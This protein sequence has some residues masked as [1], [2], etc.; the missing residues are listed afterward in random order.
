MKFVLPF[1][2]TFLYTIQSNGQDLYFPPNFSEEWETLDPQDLDWC[3]D[4]ITDFD[5]FLAES[6][7]NAF[8][9][10]KDGKIV[11]EA[12]FNDFDLNSSWYWASAGKTI[13]A[14]MIGI[15]Q[16]EGALDINDATSLYLGEGWTD[17]PSEEGN[18]TIRK[19]Y[20]P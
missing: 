20:Q 8:I 9:A 14:A 3:T 5:N 10:L 11:H 16:E 6:N 12:Y 18:I 2:F 13:T 7:S 17:C 19:D 15:A 1:L 4:K